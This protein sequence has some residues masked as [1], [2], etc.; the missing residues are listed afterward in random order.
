MVPTDMRV[1]SVVLRVAALSA[2]LMSGCSQKPTFVVRTYQMGEK[3]ALGPLIYTVFET[4]W[5]THIGVPPDE[6]VPQ[7]RYYLVRINAVNSSG[8]DVMVPNLTVEDDKG[9]SY[10][11]L[12]MDIGAPQWIGALRQVH[13]ADSVAGNLVFDCPPGHYKLRV[14]DDTGDKAALVEIPLTFTSET[15]EIPNPGEAKRT[16][17]RQRKE[18]TSR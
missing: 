16:D 2:V 14:L 15:P 5:L 4:Q 12:G 10:P 1:S 8:A 17:A 13:P 6:R 9:T 3:V 11:E 18:A 7:N